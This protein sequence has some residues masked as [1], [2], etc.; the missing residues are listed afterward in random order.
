MFVTRLLIF[1]I[2]LFNLLFIKNDLKNIRI[3][4]RNDFRKKYL[5]TVFIQNDWYLSIPN[6]NLYKIPIKDGITSD[7]LENYIGHFPI[8]SFADGNVCLAAHNCGYTN[9]YFEYI[10][11]LENGDEIFYCY[12][13]IRKKYKVEKKYVIQ[14]DDFSLLDNSDENTLTLVTCISNSPD[15]RL[16][17]KAVYE[18]EFYE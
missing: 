16:C 4:E 13:N 6:I 8:S 9:N 5:N 7:I 2:M 17:I 3:L 14:Y 18:G 12:N 15:L 1:F 10:Y 11:K